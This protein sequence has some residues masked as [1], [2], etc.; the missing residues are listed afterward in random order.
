MIARSSGQ[1]AGMDVPDF[2]L[3]DQAGSD[4]TLSDHLAAAVALVFYRGDW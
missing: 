1:D 3:K 2:T 4:W